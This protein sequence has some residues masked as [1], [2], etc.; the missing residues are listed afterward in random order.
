MLK[1]VLAGIALLCA[2][3]VMANAAGWFFSTQVRTVGGTITSRNMAGQKVTDGAIFRSYTTHAQLQVTVAADPGF[4]IRSI[5]VNQVDQGQQGTTFTTQVQGMT[6][7]SVAATFVPSSLSVTAANPGGTVSPASFG[8]LSYGYTLVAPL[9]FQFVPATGYE[10]TGIQ[11]LP[12]DA[13]VSHSPYSPGMNKAVTVTFATGYVFKSSFNLLAVVRNVTPSVGAILP[14]NVLAG[15]DVQMSVVT[16]NLS[17]PSYSWSYVSGPQN[18]G[19]Y[20]FVNGKISPNFTP[21]PALSLTNANTSTASFTAPSVP[22]QYKFQVKVSSAGAPDLTTT[23]TVNVVAA[24][25]DIGNNQCQFCH[26]ANKV[27]RSSNSSAWAA[28]THATKFVTCDRCHV[29]TTSG[30]HPGYLAGWLNEQTETGS[31]NEKSFT[32]TR[33]LPIGKSGDVF[34]VTCH[35][36]A[37]ASDF[38]SSPHNAAGKTC[39]SCHNNA[40]PMHNPNYNPAACA[41]CHA[42]ANGNVANHPLAINGNACYSCHNP[43]STQATQ[44]ANLPSVH[45]NNITTGQYPASYMTSRATC[46][47][48]HYYSDQNATIRQQ[49]AQSKHAAVTDEPWTHYDFKTMNGCVQCHTTTGFIAYSTGKVSKAWGLASDK[50]KEVL[51]CKGCH[52][53]IETGTT[54]KL[55]PVQPFA[56]GYL[57]RDLGTSNLC[58]SCHIGRTTGKSVQ[59]LVGVADFNNQGFVA[60]HYL[61]AGATLHALSGYEYAGQSYANY[62]TNSHRTVGI[63]DNQGTGSAGPCVACHMSSATSHS[64]Q[65]TSKDA[66]GVITVIAASACAKCHGSTLD[67]VSLAA[68]Q[69]GF[70]SELDALKA[71]LADKGFVYS[72]NYPYFANTAWGNG[73]A[74]ADTMGAAYNYVLLL[75]EPGAFAHNGAYAKKLIADSID[76]LYNGSVTGSIDSALA[77]LA[78]KQQ[79]PISQATADS[80]GA[81]AKSNACS[82]CHTGSTGSHPTH[83][84]HAIGCA[85]CHSGTALSNSRLVPGGLLHMNGVKDVSFSGSGVYNAGS[86]SGVYC[87][88]NGRGNYQ[89]P[90]WGTT[91]TGCIFCHP[92]AGLKGAHAAHVGTLAP[93]AYGDTG[94]RSSA[95]EYRFGCGSCHPTDLASHMNGFVEVTLVPTSDSSLRSK[96]SPSAVAAG[97]GNSGSYITGTAGSSVVC[98]A[99]YCHSNGQSGAALVYVSSPDWYNAAAYTGDRCAMCHGNSP[100]SGAHAAHNVGIHYGQIFDGSGSLLPQ[101]DSAGQPAGHGDPAQS[102]TIN[103]D[104]CHSATV[105]SNAND[106]NLACVSC[107]GSSAP[108]KGTPSLNKVSHLNGSADIAFKGIQVVSKAQVRP[109]SFGKYSTLWSRTSYKLGAG[110]FDTS[111]LKLSQGG[112]D[113][114]GK[115]CS[116]IAC[117]NGGTPNWQGK[118]SCVDCHTNL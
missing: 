85:Q 45:Y 4:A 102:T 5:L 66:N 63:N 51:T 47:N 52:S 65:A 117:H 31:V 89:A 77:Y 19:G 35:D 49:W 78:Q 108:A 90:V 110:S 96:N 57:N 11:N 42:D 73:Q 84:A 68:Q 87:H 36:R 55:A 67:A 2:V 34:C 70:L 28:S 38:A 112:W 40:N 107:H 56:D 97:I 92:L 33:D 17:N 81:Y 32:L 26:D 82:S 54:R 114:S 79:P 94:N 18:S 1:R 20:S 86:C 118:L 76:Y 80:A 8:N 74:G 109:A 30:G 100:D 29:G 104:L 75:K 22:G 46:S 71:M 44:M 27:G 101:A 83:L 39:S 62:S 98:S 53:S 3:P 23:A 93:S 106:G 60:P 21:G 64:Y 111:K 115:N 16:N 72:G 88:S 25:A 113:G 9:T 59:S 6:D 103:C 69:A 7:Q 15:K 13:K 41:G 61:S 50:T 116:N 10:I 37:I 14:Q 105:T 99:A 12:V 48:C 91:S 43:H 95:D 58:M 24:L